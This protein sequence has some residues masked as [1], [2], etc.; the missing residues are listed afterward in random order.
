ME[1]PWLDWFREAK[2]HAKTFSDSSQVTTFSD[3]V[4]DEAGLVI[5]L[6][7]RQVESRPPENS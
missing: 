7:V 3:V 6:F 2:V 4:T 5:L 1:D